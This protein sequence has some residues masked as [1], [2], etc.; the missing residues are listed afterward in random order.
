MDRYVFITST[1]RKAGEL[2]LSKSDKKLEIKTKNDD[3]QNIV[4]NLDVEISEFLTKEIQQTF[5]GEIIYSEEAQQVD[6]SSGSY[7]SI[8]PIDGTACF[9]R[10]I[11]HFAIVITYIDAGIPVVGAIFNPK[12]QELFSFKKNQGAF[13]NDT[14]V[15]VSK[16][17][18]IKDAHVF[19]TIGRNKDLWSWGE[20]MSQYLLSHA[21]KTRNFGSS[22]LDMCFVGAGRTEAC[23]Y[24]TLTTIDIAAAIGF[25]RE[26][27]GLVVD[28]SGNEIKNLTLDKQQI[29]TVNNAEML[30]TLTTGIS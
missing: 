22:A 25:V 1:I 19:L 4:T 20:K 17:T 30:S 29:I 11:P 2:L 23:I 24:G 7:W 14:K 5:P 9:S 3:N 21:N 15:Q 13:L 18:D 16:I 10:G 27:G 28:K 6:L 26:A 12:T 8:D